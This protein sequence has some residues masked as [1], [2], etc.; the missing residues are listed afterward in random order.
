LAAL[1]GPVLCACVGPVT[2]A[3]L[4]AAGVPTVQP[5]RQR[6]GALVK[7]LVAELRIRPS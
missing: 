4:E 3:P 6:L 2:A 1:R 5:E 7:L